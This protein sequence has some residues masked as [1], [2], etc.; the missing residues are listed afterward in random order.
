MKTYIYKLPIWPKFVWSYERIAELLASV[1][2]RQGRLVGRMQSLG[3]SLRAEAELEAMTL[4]VLKSSEIEGERLDRRQV[5]SSIARR[6]GMKIAGLIPSDRNVD[7]IVEMALDATQNFNKP[8]S[9]DR[10][11]GWHAALFPAGRSGM[12]KIIT[13]A[14]RDDRNGPMQ[15]VSGPIGR[16]KVHFVAPEASCLER[17]M[18][19][20]LNQFNSGSSR[21]G[22]D[23]VLK[24]GVAHLWFLTLHPF[25]DG[26]GRIARAISDMQL[27]RSDGSSQRFYSMSARMRFERKAYYDALEKAQKNTGIQKYGGLK[28]IDITAW[29]EWFLSCLDRALRS[30]EEILSDVFKKARFWEEHP[31][32][33]LN[34]RQI[35]IINKLFSGFEGKLTSSKWAK[36]AK[37]SQDTALRDITELVNKGIVVKDMAGGRSTSYHLKT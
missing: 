33:T 36:I 13:G 12:H 32:N 10:L 22:I 2:N 9:K 20:F 1:R 24:A 34:E 7:G 31:A 37:C 11:F 18:K 30:S 19:N 27:A 28:G 5:R 16:E 17:E 35:S 25:E 8:L 29:L 4:E 26:N 21:S 6:L 15:V 14:W 3:F 23:P